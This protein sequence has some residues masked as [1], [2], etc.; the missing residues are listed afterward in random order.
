M[1]NLALF[2]N[3]TGGFLE[4]NN[5][6]SGAN[7][8]SSISPKVDLTTDS[9]KVPEDAVVNLRWKTENVVS[10]EASGDWSGTKDFFGFIQI[11]IRKK[12][13]FRMACKDTDNK[14][15]ESELSIDLVPI[16]ENLFGQVIFKSGYE[17]TSELVEKSQ[18]Y[19]SYRGFDNFLDQ[20]N[21]WVDDFLANEKVENLNIFFEEGESTQRFAEI[22]RDPVDT[23]NKVLQFWLKEPNVLNSQNLPLKGRIQEI[24]KTR[25]GL[26]TISFKIR[27]F[28]HPDMNTLTEIPEA[29]DWLTISEWWNNGGWTGESFP[30]RISVNIAKPNANVGSPLFL[31]VHGEA[32]SGS[33]QNWQSGRK[34]EE[35]SNIPLPIGKW[36]N[37]HYL[38]K[39]GDLESGIFKLTMSVDGEAEKNVFEIHNFTHHPDDLAPN[40]FTDFHLLKLY[41]S[42]KVIDFMNSKNKVLQLFWDDYRLRAL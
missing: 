26:K 14:S 19:L 40:G 13:L 2:Q 17:G 29:F 5:T 27:M 4:K 20:P 28:L 11:K 35:T 33:D 16:D 39:E 31:E 18:Q 42:K 3:C 1:V 34:W 37:L 8:T 15:V 41:T 32:K 22:A 30:F 24:L 23:T 6:S 7:L 38:V 36:I 9:L 25:V 12:S 10:C 21:D